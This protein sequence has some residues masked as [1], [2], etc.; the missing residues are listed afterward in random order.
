MLSKS[1]QKHLNSLKV[2]KYRYKNSAFV[3]EGEKIVQELLQ[4]NWTIRQI[5]AVEDWLMAHESLLKPRTERMIAISEKELRQISNLHT[6][7][8]VFAEVEMPTPSLKRLSFRQHCL[9]LDHLQDPGNLGTIIRIAD[10]FGIEAI[11]CSKDCVDVYNTKVVQSAMGSLFHLP[12][13]YEDLTEILAQYPQQTAYGA[14]LQGDSIKTIDWNNKGWLIIG[15]E[16][17][18]IRPYLHDHITQRITIPRLGQ[19][20]SLNA[21]V[22]AG[23]ICG[24]AC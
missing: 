23:V 13:V 12:I 3:V 2:K 8:K 20:E 6:P 18:G 14:F 19:A 7:N 4:S 16:S 11:V 5:L 9:M 24:F 17:K 15:N 10:W 1:N 22:A 21:A